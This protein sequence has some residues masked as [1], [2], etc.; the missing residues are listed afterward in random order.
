MNSLFAYFHSL[1]A[2]AK[3]VALHAGRIVL[4]LA[5]AWVLA[6]GEDIV[7]IP[8][9]KRRKY[10]DENAAA[11]QVKLTAEELQRI[12]QAIPPGAAAGNRYPERAMKNVNG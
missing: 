10:L 4:I 6:R 9:T 3:L 1:D 12:S 11:V 5:I 2:D 8:G 7:P